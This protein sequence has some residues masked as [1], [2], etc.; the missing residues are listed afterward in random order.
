MQVS[1]LSGQMRH[2]LHRANL[3]PQRV[4]LDRKQLA[5]NI[6]DSSFSLNCHQHPGR[7]LS[8][9]SIFSTPRS[10][11]YPKNHFLILNYQQL[12]SPSLS[13]KDIY[14]SNH[15]TLLWISFFVALAHMC[16]LIFIP[17]LLFIFGFLPIDSIT[18]ILRQSVNF[19]TQASF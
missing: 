1:Q 4:Q 13:Q 6:D 7:N 8:K 15:L 9:L 11:I 17:Y 19:Y 12:L 10:A 18:S 16:T 3:K 2:L 14:N 5:W